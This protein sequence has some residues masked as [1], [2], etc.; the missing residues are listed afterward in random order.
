EAHIFNRN[1]HIHGG[2]FIVHRDYSKRALAHWGRIM[3]Q[4]KYWIENVTDKEK[5]LR[6]Y[7]EAES[8]PGPN[9]MKVVPLGPFE[10]FLNPEKI[11]GLIGHI[12]N[13]RIKF[14]GKKKIED[15]IGRFGLKAYPAGYYTLPGM[16]MWLDNLLF[17]GYPPSYG[18]YKIERVWK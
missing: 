15:F 5:F 7:G 14:H 13:G 11:D 8:L 1:C 2:F 10:V 6:A 9:Y 12:T 4:K 16:P 18:T 3:A 17:F